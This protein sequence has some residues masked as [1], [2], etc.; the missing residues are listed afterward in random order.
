MAKS[1][2]IGLIALFLRCQ[3]NEPDRGSLSKG[4]PII[5][6]CVDY[7]HLNYQDKDLNNA[8]ISAACR[9][10]SSYLL[11]LFKEQLGVDVHRY[12]NHIRVEQAKKLLAAGT[13]TLTEIAV[14]TGFAG[15]HPFSRMFKRMTGMTATEFKKNHLP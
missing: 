15:L 2:A 7:I 5:K 10:S 11:S 13:C 6:K 9:I 4:W 14:R 8:K 12:V 3:T 1:F